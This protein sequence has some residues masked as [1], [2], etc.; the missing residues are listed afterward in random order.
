MK[1]WVVEYDEMFGTSIVEGVFSEEQK[2]LNF[3][4]TKDDFINYNIYEMEIDY[5]CK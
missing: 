1:V 2:A 4:S 5:L 3:V